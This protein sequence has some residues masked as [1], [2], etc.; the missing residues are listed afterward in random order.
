MASQV[1]RVRLLGG[2]EVEVDARPIPA[3]RWRRRRAAA[4]VKLLSLASDHRL[5]REQVIDALWPDM[6]ARAGGANLR[7]AAHHARRTV[8]VDEAIV[9][10]GA[11]AQLLPSGHVVTDV[12]GFE[13][14]A[15]EALARGDVDLS[16]R[17]ATS[18]GGELL[19]DDRYEP[20]CDQ[21]REQLQRVYR[22]LLAVGRLWGRLLA[23]DPTNERAHRGV[24]REHLAARDRAGAIRQFDQM[25]T[26]LRE[27]LGVG[28]DPESVALYEAVLAFEGRDVPTP[29]E[30]ARALLAWATIHWERSDLDEAER[31]AT[32]VRALAVDAGLGR[33]LADASELIGLVAF[34]RG[35][36]QEV[37]AREFLKTIR[38]TPQLAPFVYD[39]NMCMSEFALHRGDGL[40]RLARF[41]DDLVAV[42]DETGS[43]QARGLALLLHGEVGL[44][45]GGDAPGVAALLRQAARLH[46]ATA[47]KTG[48]ILATERLAQL[49]RSRGHTTTASRLHRR[50]RE[51]AAA[52]AVSNHLLPLVYGGMLEDVDPAVGI[53][54]VD[55][56]DAALSEVQPCDPCSMLL[57]VHASMSCARQGQL[58]R[59]R[60]H[61]DQAGRIAGMWNDGPWHASVKEARA[62]LDHADGGDAEQIEHLLESAADGFRA[63]G[64]RREAARCR[65]ALRFT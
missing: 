28:P 46:E 34:A 8:G 51:L 6:D 36:W 7:K 56:A 33:E 49:E 10:D 11:T 24:I 62:V 37:F 25:R 57:H 52:S 17:A 43:D 35:R 13:A 63:A 16:R 59:A 18:Y 65:T 9:L 61:V 50:A 45:A 41:A 53:G 26:A 64:R 30:R 12:A 15:R 40:Q 3:D 14:A 20:W 55:E 38:L 22:E 19:P 1:L 21:R 29:A 48:V 2:F 4:L 60:T 5:P 47:S 23:V 54:I 39:A 44:L 58:D 32:E 27:H 31:S 42:A